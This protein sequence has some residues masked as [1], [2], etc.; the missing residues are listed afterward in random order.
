MNLTGRELGPQDAL[1]MYWIKITCVV[2]PQAFALT[3]V[4]EIGDKTFFIAAILAAGSSAAS[5]GL[6]Q[7]AAWKEWCVCV[8][9]SHCLQLKKV[10]SI[11]LI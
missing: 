11:D 6:S 3:F 2:C 5:E 7:K 1:G 4:S 10:D 8:S 9:F